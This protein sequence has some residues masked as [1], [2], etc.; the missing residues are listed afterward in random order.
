MTE[1]I[2][3]SVVV[4]TYNRAYL[5]GKTIDSILAQDYGRFEVIV[6]DDGSTDN[7]EEVLSKYRGD[8]RFRCFKKNNEERGA[9]RNFG[10]NKAEGQYVFF[11]D[12]DDLMNENHLRVLNSCIQTLPSAPDF[13]APGFTIINPDDSFNYDGHPYKSGWYDRS[14]LLK[15]NPFACL[16]AVKKDNPALIPYTENR[17]LAV[18]ED[19]IF[20]LE[21]LQHKKIYVLDEIT[22]RMV[23]HDQRS[24]ADNLAV[25]A[26]RQK[27]TAYLLK[28]VNFTAR[29][30]RLLKAFSNYFCAVHSSIEGKKA[31]AFSYLAKSFHTIPLQKTASLTI[32]LLVGKRVFKWLKKVIKTYLS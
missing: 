5:V 30:Q 28:K 16:V 6:V 1:D 27:A 17:E 15:G 26:K 31:A 8:N 13:I 21:N 32:K 9:A 3:F 10:F 18:M 24:M 4:P 22:I 11:I 29:E 7:T 14:I 20:L 23:E 2:F 19:W 12:S 25:I